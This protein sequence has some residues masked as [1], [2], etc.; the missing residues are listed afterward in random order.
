[1]DMIGDLKLDYTSEDSITELEAKI[2]LW[3]SAFLKIYQEKM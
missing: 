2:V 3:F 1:M